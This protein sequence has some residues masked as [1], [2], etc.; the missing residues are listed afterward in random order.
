MKKGAMHL[1]AVRLGLPGRHRCSQRIRVTDILL[2]S[3]GH[4]SVEV[5]QVPFVCWALLAVF[6]M[7]MI[8]SKMEM[9]V[10]R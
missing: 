4:V 7:H 8:Y 3:I 1:L 6:L 9:G 5:T 2:A 10:P